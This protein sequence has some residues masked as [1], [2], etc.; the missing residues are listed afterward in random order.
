[1]KLNREAVFLGIIIGT[2]VA[3]LISNSVEASLISEVILAL[4]CIYWYVR[5][6]ATKEDGKQ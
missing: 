4:G 6:V 3:T 2:P 1:M 5:K